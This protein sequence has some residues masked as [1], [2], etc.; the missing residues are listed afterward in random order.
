M[1]V[2][3]ENS[4]SVYNYI[5]NNY[6]AKMGGKLDHT[7]KQRLADIGLAAMDLKAF[8]F[9][10]GLQEKNFNELMN[11][12]TSTS[13]SVEILRYYS[14]IVFSG[15]TKRRN[16]AKDDYDYGQGKFSKKFK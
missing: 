3:Y 9:K 12:V 6:E 4:T 11:F 2:W 8:V 16:T 14:N 1:K 7:L 13:G 15:V 10:F 5:V